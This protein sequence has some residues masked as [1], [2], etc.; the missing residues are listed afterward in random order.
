MT[1][2]SSAIAKFDPV[3]EA[4]NA[5]DGVV[6][7]HPGTHPLSK[8]VKLPWPFFMMEYLFDTTRAVVNLMF[9]GALER[10]P[11]IRFILPH[12]GGLVPYFSWRLVGVADDRQAAEAAFEG[13]S[14]R[15]AAALLVRQRALAR[16]ADLGLPGKCRGARPD[17]VRHRLAVRQRQRH[18]GGN[19]DL[20]RRSMRSRPRSAPRSTAATRCGCFRSSRSVQWSNAKRPP[21]KP[22]V[23]ALGLTAL[24]TP[25]AVH[26]FF[27]VIPAV[28]A[29]LGLT[30]AHA[31]LTF[32]ISLFGMAFA[33]LFYGSLS[34]RYGRRPVLLSGL[35]LFLIGSVVSAIA[36]DRKRAGGGPADP[37]GRRGLRA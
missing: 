34:D 20:C 33:T 17:R 37:G 32:S 10:Y 3:M 27:P 35:A 16:R 11:R 24:I 5:R 28:K 22:F 8:D 2:S 31:Q 19:E 23:I 1:A 13:R 4:L 36:R 25:L 9:G 30:D 29:A 7:V 26:L 18:R 21:G 12:A 15:A 14:V 6:F